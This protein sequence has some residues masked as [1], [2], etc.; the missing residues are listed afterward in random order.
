[1]PDDGEKTTTGASRRLSGPD[2]Q[3]Q[4]TCCGVVRFARVRAPHARLERVGPPETSRRLEACAGPR[5]DDA[6][7]LA[8]G[9]S[10]GLVGTLILGWTA[11]RSPGRRPASRENRQY[12]ICGCSR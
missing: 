9:T 4:G 10:T 3:D 5:R 2:T 1:M 6:L 8:G 11:D 12:R 7:D